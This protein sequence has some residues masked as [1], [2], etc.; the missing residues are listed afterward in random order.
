MKKSFHKWSQMK[1]SAH[2]KKGFS[3]MVIKDHK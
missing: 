2:E 1:I 3:R